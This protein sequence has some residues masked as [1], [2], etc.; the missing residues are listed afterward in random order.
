MQ[1]LR[2]PSLSGMECLRVALLAVLLAVAPAAMAQ[3][4]L[5][6]VRVQLKWTHQFQFAGY[7][8]A[9]HKGYYRDAGFDVHLLEHEPGVTPIDLLIGGRV[10]YAVGDSG[11]LL[12]RANGA[13]L[14]ALAA[15]FQESPSILLTLESSGIHELADLR[16]RRVM[17]L[18]GYLNAELMTMLEAAGVRS[19]DFTLLPPDTDVTALVEGRTDA[20][21]AYTT[22][23]PFA[24]STLGIP[25]R[26]FA[27]NDYGVDFYADILVTT[28]S[29]IARDPDGVR[30]F[31]DATLRG[32]RYA[33]ENPD[34]IVGLIFDEYNTQGRSLEHLQFEAQEAIRLMLPNL[35]PV[36][37]MNEE[38]WRR[39]EEVFRRQ[40]QLKQPVD[41]R[42]FLHIPEQTPSVMEVLQDHRLEI[43][44]GVAALIALAMLTHILRLRAQVAARTRE[45]DLARLRAET[46]A[47]TD[48][49]T[50]LP[51]RRH[52]LEALMRDLARAERENLPLSLLSIDIDHFKHVNDR[53]GHA[54]GDKA[55]RHTADALSAHVRSSDVAARIGG[56]EFALSCL[57]T[58][59]DV[60]RHLAERLR[61]AIESIRAEHGGQDFGFTVS[62]GISTYQPGDDVASL[63]Q[64]ADVALYAA[65]QAGRNRVQE[66]PVR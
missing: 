31:V 7:Y 19:Q 59:P 8:A 14:V 49:L 47:R 24:L 44:G 55:L 56:E 2:Q 51:N 4:S 58:G 32:W 3:K 30:R 63:L 48:A 22:N 12:Y 37:Y 13:P 64:R 20:Y 42:R 46:E 39:I 57:N 40:G 66:S 54:A 52:F 34:E 62:I 43:G 11:V 33:V 16:G 10:E 21:N 38:R 45:L 1:M 27:P 28:E 36:G 6:P 61:S 25:H 18:G 5:E 65:K 50:G 41:M 53:H 35:V 29:V 17:L 9:V 26:I 15:I 23:E 60:A